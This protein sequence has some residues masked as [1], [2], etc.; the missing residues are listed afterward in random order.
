MSASSE[1]ENTQRVPLPVPGAF[2]FGMS[3]YIEQY[4]NGHFLRIIEW[5]LMEF[6]SDYKKVSSIFN[7]MASQHKIVNALAEMDDSSQYVNEISALLT[8]F[9]YV[10]SMVSDFRNEIDNMLIYIDKLKI[11]ML[12]ASWYECRE[13]REM[14]ELFQNYAV[15][16]QQQAIEF[17]WL[18]LSNLFDCA[19]GLQNTIFMHLF[20]DCKFWFN[21][22][23]EAT[24]N[25]RSLLGFDP[26]Y[27][28][29]WP[30]TSGL[31]W[32]NCQL[33]LFACRC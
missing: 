33:S 21:W 6:R 5:F 29:E 31:H 18:L 15:F 25:D 3:Q 17:G 1:T 2:K 11:N 19:F 9:F 8:S 13:Y 27:Y 22:P 14:K 4:P 30:K 12:G 26:N 23:V 16:E 24:D 32:R 28:S 10:K 20:K 7:Q